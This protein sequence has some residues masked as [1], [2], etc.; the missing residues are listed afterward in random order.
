MK[1][2][3]K[4]KQLL[5]GFV[6]PSRRF[7]ETQ[8]LPEKKPKTFFEF[9]RAPRLVRRVALGLALVSVSTFA[10]LQVNATTQLGSDSRIDYTANLSATDVNRSIGRYSTTTVAVPTG[11][12]TFTMQMWVNPGPVAGAANSS[13]RVLFN[14]ENKFAIGSDQGKWVY[15]RGNGSSWHNSGVAVVTG[16]RVLDNRWT[17]IS[18]VFTASNTLFYVD[19][20]LA[21]STNRLDSGSNNT[22]LYMGIG[23]W[24]PQNTF[25]GNLFDGQV[26][27]VKLWNADR[28]TTIATDMHSR[29]IGTSGLAHYWDFNEGSGS[30][31][32]DRIGGV[33]LDSN[34]SVVFSDVKQTSSVSGGDTVLTF[35]RTYLAAGGGWTPPV[36]ASNFRAL[37]VGGGGGGGAPN[38]STGWSGGGG[39]AGGLKNLS[40]LSLSGIQTIKVGQGGNGG[41]GANQR[42]PRLEQSSG[43][44]SQLGTNSVSGGGRGGGG[45]L[46]GDVQTGGSGGGGRMYGGDGAAGIAGEGNRGGNGAVHHSAGG[47][48]GAGGAG[49]NGTSTSIN[50]A[51]GGAGGAGVSLDISGTSQKYAW[52]GAGAGWRNYG[53]DWN[54]SSR[55]AAITPSANTGAGGGGGRHTPNFNNFAGSGASGST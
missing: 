49:G 8:F 7:K 38:D 20:Q 12:N 39:G 11:F 5:Q 14:M 45:Y 19:G 32:H 18:L 51:D 50:D 43:Q 31:V 37:V 47:G 55:T 52:G 30:T 53:T 21:H 29:Q 9:L 15:W 25:Q 1:V 35:P 42:N 54:T 48:G 41:L 26:D 40:N 24:A 36:S 16:V 10:A 17:H 6:L 44:G 34:S 46:F 23:N 22:V 28:S 3:H 4:A 13:S 33:H 27:E 2:L